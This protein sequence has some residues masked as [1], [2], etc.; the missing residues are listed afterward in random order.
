MSPVGRVYLTDT[1]ALRYLTCL[2]VSRGSSE[3]AAREGMVLTPKHRIKSSID[4]VRADISCGGR[5]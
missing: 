2:K 5:I 1:A 3:K 4:M